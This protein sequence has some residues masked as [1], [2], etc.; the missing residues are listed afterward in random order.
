VTPGPSPIQPERLRPDPKVALVAY[1]Y[2]SESKPGEFH[3]A[4]LMV[5][6]E[7][8]QDC[9]RGPGSHVERLK[10]LRMECAQCFEA[11]RWWACDCRGFVKHDHCWHV[12]DARKRWAEQRRIHSRRPS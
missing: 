2:P 10:G 4:A 12:T 11:L 8:S 3:D 9:S 6:E 1:R 5:S 7:N